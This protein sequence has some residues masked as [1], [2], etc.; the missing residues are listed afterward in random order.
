MTDD[1]LLLLVGARIRQLRRTRKLTQEDMTQFGFEVKYYQR[2]EYGQV[3]L[4]LRSLNRLAN[5]FGVPVVEFLDLKRGQQLVPE[6]LK[7]RRKSS[8]K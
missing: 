6:K 3:N 2:I 1:R 8:R 4:T 5:A 7:G